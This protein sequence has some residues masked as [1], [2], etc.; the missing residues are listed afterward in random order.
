MKKS[1]KKASARRNNRRT[2]RRLVVVLCALIVML[3]SLLYMIHYESTRRDILRR[4]AEYSALYTAPTL[5]PAVASSPTPTAPAEVTP[6]PEPAPSD[7]V[8]VDQT[9]APLAT[10]DAETLVVSMETPPPVQ[11]SFN[12]LLAANPETVGFLSIDDVLALPVVQRPNDNEFYLDHGFDLEENLGGTLFLDGSNLL[13]PEDGCLIV[14]GHNMRNGTMFRP[15][16]SYEDPSFLKENA[17]VRF[18]TLYDNRVYVPFAALTVTAEPDSE[19]YLNLRQFTF[20]RSGLERFVKSLRALSVWSS[21]VEVE[22]GDRILL[23]VTCEYTHDNGRFVLALRAQRDDE[24]PDQ[25][26]AQAQQTQAK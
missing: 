11:E 12:A 15:L 20:D 1:A 22:Y 5:A 2:E 4:N 10:P 23:L 9:R 8:A 21:P 3:G 14:Y 24:A 17:L 6:T 18:D 13:V 25:L 7:E 26:W 16:I 19:R